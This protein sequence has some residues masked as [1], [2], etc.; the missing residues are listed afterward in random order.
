LW[1][2]AVAQQG[3]WLQLDNILVGVVIV[4][5]VDYMKMMRMNIYGLWLRSRPKAT[6]K[7]VAMTL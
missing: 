5:S 4:L 2:I 6:W 7:E 3:L 1:P